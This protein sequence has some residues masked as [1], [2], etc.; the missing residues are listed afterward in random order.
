MVV[1]RKACYYIGRVAY[2]LETWNLDSRKHDEDYSSRTAEN[3]YIPTERNSQSAIAIRLS[4][5][6]GKVCSN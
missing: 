1:N 5:P 4:A 2:L 6:N 3:L